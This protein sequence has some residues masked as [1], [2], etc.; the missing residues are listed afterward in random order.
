MD[1][2]VARARGRERPLGADR[3][4]DRVREDF[5]HLAYLLWAKELQERP[6]LDP[7]EVF[8]QAG[9]RATASPDVN[10]SMPSY[11]TRHPR[12]AHGP[13]RSP[14]TTWL[15]IGRDAGEI[16]DPGH[17]VVPLAPLLRITPEQVVDLLQRTRDDLQ[18]RLRTGTLG[19]MFAKAAEIEPLIG[20]VW[21][22]T[23]R[24]KIP[25]FGS[26][27]VAEQLAA[28]DDCHEQAGRRS[29]RLLFVVN[30]PR[31]GGGR[32]IEGH[33]AHA[34]A[35]RVSPEDVAVVYTDESGSTPAG[36]FPAGV[37]EIDFARA[38]RGVTGDA[39]DHLLAVLVRSFG[40]DSVVNV[41][42]AAFYRALI[43]YGRALAVSERVFLCLFC[44]EQ[45]AQGNWEGWSLKHL[46]RNLDQVAGVLT[47]SE[48]LRDELAGRYLLGARE[49]SRIHVLR[50]PVEPELPVAS[51]PAAIDGRRP[52]VFWAGRWDRQKRVDLAV[53]A[54]RRMPEADFRLWGE[55][56]LDGDPL[57]PLPANV[58][59]EGR[60]GHISE[61]ALGEADVWLYTSAWDGV[62]SLLLEVAMTEV[63]IVASRVGGVGEVLGED[64]AHLVADWADADA[65]VRALRAVLADPMAARARSRSLRGRLERDRS[66]AG[67]GAAA[68]AVLLPPGGEGER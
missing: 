37:R 56:V 2:V 30:R 64:D 20:G 65:Y 15:T 12:R 63:P 59:L 54:A 44:N 68:A 67:F 41:N 22:E 66:Q 48:Y 13:D 19:E 40:A 8:L 39:R 58:R 62:P 36:R 25:P 10:F 27:V 17:G 55:R 21:P 50:A 53:E 16:A 45:R 60:Y 1:A 31:W 34:L 14:Y 29:A 51:T 3:E 42:S 26:A 49:L 57:G 43:P 38:A 6:D 11:L 18:H 24:P 9:P 23:I 4:Y 7:I 35:D 28:L 33:L 5:D 46:Y 61:L 52:Q 32:R 47:D